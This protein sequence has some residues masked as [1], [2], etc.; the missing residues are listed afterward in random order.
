MPTVVRT[1]RILIPQEIKSQTSMTGRDRLPVGECN[2]RGAHLLPPSRVVYR[3]S[4]AR[5]LLLKL[6]NERGDGV[7]C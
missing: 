2:E 1:P 4:L 3:S 5:Q 7:V 6:V